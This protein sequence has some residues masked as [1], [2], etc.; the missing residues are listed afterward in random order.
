M[1]DQL[2]IA[3]HT[4]FA[5]TAL[6]IMLY[7]LWRD[8]RVDKFRQDMFAL[9]DSLFDYAAGGHISFSHP[10]YG[11]LRTRMNGMIRFAHEATIGHLGLAFVTLKFSNKDF[12]PAIALKEWEKSVDTIADAK[13]REQLRRFHLEMNALLVGNLVKGS[14]ILMLF[15]GIIVIAAMMF[16]VVKILWEKLTAFV[17]GLAYLEAEAEVIGAT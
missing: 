3:F 5:W 7:W 17:P 2:G 8:Y 10:A 16:G 14:V 11:I 15:F 1:V 12:D 9:R 13:V 6:W 4:Y